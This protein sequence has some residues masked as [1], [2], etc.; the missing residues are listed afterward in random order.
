M[1][2]AL[3]PAFVKKERAPLMALLAIN[4]RL[5]TLVLNIDNQL[6][7]ET[8]MAVILQRYLEEFGHKGCVRDDLLAYLHNG[9]GVVEHGLKS[10]LEA[11]LTETSVSHPANPYGISYG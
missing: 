3:Q 10:L 1:D 8:G 4:K 2:L 9:D 11:M 6:P 7:E 5:D